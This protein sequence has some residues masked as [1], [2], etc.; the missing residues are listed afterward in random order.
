MSE[1]EKRDVELDMAGMVISPSS[2]I[3]DFWLRLSVMIIGDPRLRQCLEGVS[4]V[5][6]LSV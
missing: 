3:F 4:E 1:R 6:E 2:S 5:R